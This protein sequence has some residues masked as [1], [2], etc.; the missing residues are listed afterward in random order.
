[1]HEKLTP[2][3]CIFWEFVV[4]LNSDEKSLGKVEEIVQIQEDVMY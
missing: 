2:V 4:L 1:V 3:L